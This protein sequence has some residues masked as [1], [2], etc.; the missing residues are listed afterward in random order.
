MKLLLKANLILLLFLTNYMLSQTMTDN[1]RKY[2][3][4][5][6]RLTNDFMKVGLGQGEINIKKIVVQ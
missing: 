1:H 6:S 2:W 5:K 3:W 4:Y